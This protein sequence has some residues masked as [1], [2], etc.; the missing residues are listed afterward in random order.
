MI[1]RLLALLLALALPLHAALNDAPDFSD[2]V[3]NTRY[4]HLIQ[5]IRCPTCQNSNIAESNAPLARQLREQIAARIRDG[6]SDSD[7]NHW[8]QERYGD[9]IHY[10]PPLK[11]QT[12]ILWGGAPLTMLIALA[13]W[14]A[15][16]RRKN[17]ARLSDEEKRQ[18]QQWIDDAT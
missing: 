2:P 1:R 14:L 8:L 13:L 3:E 4:Q 7:I 15:G 17:G 18:L 12:L 6:A 16:R 11:S 9:F 10:D 5:N